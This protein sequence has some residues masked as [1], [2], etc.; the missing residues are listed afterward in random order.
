[1]A[2]TEAFVA[3]LYDTGGP[4]RGVLLPGM[5]AWIAGAAAYFVAGSAGG[6]IPAFAVSVLVYAVGSRLRVKPE[7]R[8]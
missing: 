6:T 2:I 1:V 3:S 4:L 5:A 8:V 7:V